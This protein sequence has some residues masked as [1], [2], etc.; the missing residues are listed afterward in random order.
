MYF[1]K[2]GIFPKFFVLKV[3]LQ[4]VMLLWHRALVIDSCYGALEIVGVIII[5]IIMLLLTVSYRKNG[6]A[7][8][9]K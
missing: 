9:I 7:G 6:A 2:A 3:T 8:C 1:F 5:I 4:S